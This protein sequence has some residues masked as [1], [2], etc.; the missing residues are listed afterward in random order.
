MESKKGF[1]MAHLVLPFALPGLTM[2]SP[3]GQRFS[4]ASM[5]FFQMANVKTS[6]LIRK[7]P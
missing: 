6:K 7:T 1:F 4:F 5:A 2:V 3:L